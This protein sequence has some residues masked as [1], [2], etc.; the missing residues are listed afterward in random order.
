M[1]IRNELE[2]FSSSMIL[3]SSIMD[4]D[5]TT[6]IN[7]MEE[8]EKITIDTKDNDDDLYWNTTTTTKNNNNNEEEE[9]E[10]E[11]ITITKKEYNNIKLQLKEKELII[12]KYK[13]ERNN[14]LLYSFFVIVIFS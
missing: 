4:N 1:G 10:E 12:N 3:K 14:I 13:L 8:S 11:K 6:A 7:D 9:D 5:V 2:T